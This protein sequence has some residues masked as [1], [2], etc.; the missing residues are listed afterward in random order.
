MGARE[1]SSGDLLLG[2]LLLIA[3]GVA[4]L[5]LQLGLGWRLLIAAV[6]TVV[7][8]WLLGLVLNWVFHSADLRWVLVLVASMIVN[9]GIAAVQR[10]EQRFVGVWS[11]A[12]VSVSVSAIA[13][14]LIVTAAVIDVEPWYA[15]R[16]LIPILGMVLG[17]TLTGIS[18]CLERAVGDL[19]QRR[20][21]VEG[22]L[23]LG[24]TVWEACRDIIAGAIRASLIPI[25]N[26]M[27]VVGIVS[28]PGMMTG[29]I[30]AGARPLDAAKYQIIVMFMIAGATALG[31]VITGLLVFRHLSTRHHQLCLPTR[32]GPD[33]RS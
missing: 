9:A 28:L 6:R 5:A 1:L 14:T 4:S 12:L 19:R 7:Q 18:L 20:A 3:V 8:L 21:E 17:N 26:S 13:T 15:P 11:T 29:Q 27:S 30:L 2:S 16:Y 24:A 10:S 33:R 25:L 31:S 23:L 32:P 22:L